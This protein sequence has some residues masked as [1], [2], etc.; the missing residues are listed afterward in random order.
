MKSKM[1]KWLVDGIDMELKIMDRGEV[2][3]FAT[4]CGER[5]AKRRKFHRIDIPKFKLPY[6]VKFLRGIPCKTSL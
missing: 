1:Y 6:I 4:C 3:T 2:I 5:L